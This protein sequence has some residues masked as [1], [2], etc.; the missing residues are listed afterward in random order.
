ML[1]EAMNARNLPL[2]CVSRIY[3][4]RM[5]EL[6]VPKYAEICARRM[7]EALSLYACVS[8]EHVRLLA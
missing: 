1:F 7:D 3:A 6:V 5:A 4:Q 8:C 2:F